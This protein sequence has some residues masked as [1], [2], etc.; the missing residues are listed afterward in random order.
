MF[1]QTITN[2]TIKRPVVQMMLKRNY[3]LRDIVEP[4]QHA[5]YNLRAAYQQNNSAGAVSNMA[6]PTRGYGKVDFDLIQ[7]TQNSSYSKQIKH[8]GAT[9]QFRN[10]QQSRGN[11]QPNHNNGQSYYDEKL[12]ASPYLG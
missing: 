5:A 12:A 1:R 7:K 8:P 10:A 4:P 6:H 2:H 11:N 9:H 3:S